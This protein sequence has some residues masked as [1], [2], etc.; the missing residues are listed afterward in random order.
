MRPMSE[1]PDPLPPPADFYSAQTLGPHNSLGLLVKRLMSSM[2]LQADRRLVAHD[3]THAQWLPLYRLHKGDC[4]TTAELARELVLDPGAM[5]RAL[6][7][8]EAKG[9]IRRSRSQQDR[10]V[11]EIELTASGRTAA[12]VVPGVMAEVL[13]AHLAGF[14]HDEWQQLLGLLHRL[15]ANGDALREG[16]VPGAPPAA[17][18]TPSAG[19]AA[20]AGAADE[21]ADGASAA[22][23]G[24]DAPAGSAV[25]A[26]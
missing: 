4:G 21:G 1:T 14:S 7:R 9:L 10:R 8:L 5:T 24:P 19:T 26:P 2:M 11:V 16:R 20:A 13:N 12:E 23:E 25:P 17:H 22:A 18:A 15:V 3:L 6:D